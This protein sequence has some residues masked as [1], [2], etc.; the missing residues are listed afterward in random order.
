MLAAT[1]RWA[2]L[3]TSRPFHRGLYRRICAS[4]VPPRGI[5]LSLWTSLATLPARHKLWSTRLTLP[6]LRI[7]S[8]RRHRSWE[9][10]PLPTASGSKSGSDGSSARGSKM[11]AAA[12]QDGAKWEWRQR[13]RE[14]NGSGGSTRWSKMGTA[15]AQE[16]AKEAAAAAQEGAKWERRQHKMEQN[17]SGGSPRG[18]K[19]GAAAGAAWGAEASGLLGY[20]VWGRCFFRFSTA[21]G[22]SVVL[23]C[24]GIWFCCMISI[25]HFCVLVPCW[26]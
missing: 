7:S 9:R 1:P 22:L 6:A 24:I 21:A 26:L 18:S 5:N 2:T 13:K 25:W 3:P 11:G 12:A 16:G 4:I 8:R 20:W 10:P 19:M 23:R 14:Q 15:A 17:G